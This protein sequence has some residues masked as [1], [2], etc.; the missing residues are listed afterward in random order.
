MKQ[1]GGL[2]LW[3]KPAAWTLG[4][5]D[6]CLPGSRA[7]RPSLEGDRRAVLCPAPL[8]VASWCLG[9]PRVLSMERRVEELV[10]W[11]RAPRGELR[12]WGW[13]GGQL[14]GTH[15]EA[16]GSLRSQHLDSVR[17]GVDSHVQSQKFLLQPACGS[18]ATSGPMAPSGLCIIRLSTHAS[19]GAVTQRRTPAPPC[20]PVKVGHGRVHL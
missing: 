6:A 12:G 14:S 20:H 11:Q 15:R 2:V 18:K 16:E 4:H 5:K 7:R 8:V 3:T 19:E 9:G 1:R 10:C 17:C 13:G